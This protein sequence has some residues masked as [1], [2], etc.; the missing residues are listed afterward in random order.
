MRFFLILILITSCSM[1]TVN[2]QL[3]TQFITEKVESA[4]SE[5]KETFNI[6]NVKKTALDLEESIT[7]KTET[8][9][10]NI[11]GLSNII[12]KDLNQNISSISNKITEQINLFI[13]IFKIVLIV[14]LLF[15][16]IFIIGFIRRNLGLDTHT[17]ELKKIR[18]LLNEIIEI[19][20]SN[21]KD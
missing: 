4:A 7:K 8:I 5:L 11:S 9:N 15:F 13:K 14:V 19:N 3:N 6:N 21:I 16:I 12:T 20:K 18:K 2:A 10:Q 1:F 17:K